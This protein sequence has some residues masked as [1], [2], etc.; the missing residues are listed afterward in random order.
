LQAWVGS[1]TSLGWESKII[2]S[3]L[4]VLRGVGFS[5]FYFP[6]STSPY[7][8]GPAKRSECK[9]QHHD[10]VNDCETQQPSGRAGMPLTPRGDRAVEREHAE[11]CSSSFMKKL[12][13]RAPDDAQGD[14]RRVPER[15]IEAC[16]H[17]IILVHIVLSRCPFGRVFMLLIAFDVQKPARTAR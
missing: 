2:A 5:I 3:R 4:A 14:F 15:R 8:A 13:R 11:N 1:R 17:A 12:A 6:I 9:Y 7:A 16:D 10:G